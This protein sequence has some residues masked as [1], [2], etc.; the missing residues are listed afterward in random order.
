MTWLSDVEESQR[1]IAVEVFC[2]RIS[3]WSAARRS[4]AFSATL[5]A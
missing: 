4:A 5:R 3:Y 2:T 1:M